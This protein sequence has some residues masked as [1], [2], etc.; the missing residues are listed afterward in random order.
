M[1]HNANAVRQWEPA[2]AGISAHHI[3]R[4]LFAANRV[5]PQMRV[6]DA[7]CGCGYGAWL[8]HCLKGY[9][10]ALDMESEAIKYGNAYYPGPRYVQADITRFKARSFSYDLVTSFETIE[11]LKEPHGFL[12]SLESA[13]LIASVPNQELYPFNQENFK[14]DDYP[15]QRHYT[16]GE[17][18]TLLA[19][20]G[21]VTTE[22]WCQTDKQH[23]D[24]RPGTNGKFLVYVAQPGR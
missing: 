15:H 9:V 1:N 5:R 4:Y 20:C 18:E 19:E 6:L 17:F 2:L 16:P 7:A 11:H 23:S 24:V 3:K 10:D 13:T 12:R 14:G 22:R 21:F 8:L